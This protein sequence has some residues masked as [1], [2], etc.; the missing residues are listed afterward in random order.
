[1]KTLL[2]ERKENGIVLATLNRPKKANALS[3]QLLRELNDF[4]S[5]IEND[6]SLRVVIF[7]G[8]DHHVFCAG[9]DL[10]ERKE[11]DEHE[12]RFAVQKIKMT[13]NRVANLKLPTIA[14][15]NGTALGGGLELAL[16]CDI[17]IGS[18][19]GLYGLT[20]TSLA[21]IPGAGGTQRLSRLVGIGKAKEMIF[22]AKRITGSIAAEIGLVE[23]VWEKEEVLNKAIELASTIAHNG[24]IA[25]K[26][27]KKA[28]NLGLEVDLNTALTIETNSYEATILT[29]DRLEG[30]VAFQEKRKP[31][32][33]GK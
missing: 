33:K 24:P 15:M 18:M 30:L 29:E 27:A 3:L 1:M 26:E 16:A 21:I 4:L 32:Y 14:A 9:A 20:E 5:S 12:V 11:M 17:R 23:Q 10:K 13:I 31:H 7:T 28:I 8:K 25:I 22:T 19:D 2:I 6:P